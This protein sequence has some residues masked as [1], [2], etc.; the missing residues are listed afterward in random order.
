M[1]TKRKCHQNANVTK[2]QMPPKCKHHQNENFPNHKCHQNANVTKSPIIPKRKCRR[3]ANVAETQM[4]PKGQCH[5]NAN[6]TKTQISPLEPS[7]VFLYLGSGK[8]RSTDL[9]HIN[10]NGLPG[11]G[12]S[13]SRLVLSSCNPNLNGILNCYILGHLDIRI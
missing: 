6:I 5:Q 7:F 12:L 9:V 8:T 13:D 10:A 4:S 11:H 1:S 2:M 3:N